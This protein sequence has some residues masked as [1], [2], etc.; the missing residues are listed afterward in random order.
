[1]AGVISATAQAKVRASTERAMDALVV[2]LRGGKGVLDKATGRVS[3]LSDAATVY[4][5]PNHPGAGGIA[6]I[7]TVTGQGSVSNGVGQIDTRQVVVSIPW[8]AELPRRDDLVCVIDG[9]QDTALAGAALRVVEVAGGTRFAD[10]RR[11]SCTLWGK[12]GY[13][14]GEGS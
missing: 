7:H 3:G 13:W 5:D 9:G 4:D 2:I 12:S 10:A 11:M 6:G 8:S 1:M 14:T